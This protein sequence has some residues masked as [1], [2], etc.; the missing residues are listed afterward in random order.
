MGNYNKDITSI[1]GKIRFHLPNG[2]T[3]VFKDSKSAQT[4]FNENTPNMYMQDYVA[5]D[6]NIYDSGQLPEV[7]VTAQK[8]NKD[9]DKPNDD[10]IL[11]IGNFIN[12]EIL[13][14]KNNQRAELYSKAM[15]AN[16]DFS[17]NWDMASNI[18]EHYNALTGGL[19]NRL[20]PT[21]NIRLAYDLYN[22]GDVFKYGGSWW[23]NSGILSNNFT[24]QHPFL[25]TLING[26]GDV[27]L[28]TGANSFYKW[29]TTPRVIGEG[30]EARVVTSPFS[31]Y[32]TKYT[33]IPRSDMHI[34]G[35][36]PGFLRSTYL[37]RNSLGENV[38]RQPKVF[39][40]KNYQK[41]FKAISDKLVSRGYKMYTHPN[42]LEPA[43]IKNGLALSDFG[44][45]QIGRTWY[46]KPVI[47]DMSV[48]TVPDFMVNIEKNGGKLIKD[49]SK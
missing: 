2:A 47:I 6:N 21:Q 13:L 25:S 10:I 39:V 16:P 36:V 22:N 43:F 31:P 49:K 1:K 18:S 44:P 46:G 5:P 42:L 38:F 23:G 12:D 34:R 11:S 20:S 9:I 30:A 4:W 14:N 15:E 35:M 32:V 19:L 48:E 17:K 3:K 24:K 41:P 7:V 26:V 37:G 29:G 27:S 45:G 28:Y 33:I 8:I 40:S